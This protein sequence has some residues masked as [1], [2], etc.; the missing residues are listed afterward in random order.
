MPATLTV[1]L[2]PQQATQLKKA[3][4]A[5]MHWW[6]AAKKGDGC[7]RDAFR[8][9]I[10]RFFALVELHVDPVSCDR[11]DYSARNLRRRPREDA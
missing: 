10:D 8:R 6:A 4:D 3:H 2:R 5:M 1:P 9:H 7:D 11:L